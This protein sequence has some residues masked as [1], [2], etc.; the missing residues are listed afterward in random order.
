MT[1]E[2]CYLIDQSY[3]YADIPDGWTPVQANDEDYPGDW[4]IRWVAP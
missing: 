3:G 4:A 1:A 2:P